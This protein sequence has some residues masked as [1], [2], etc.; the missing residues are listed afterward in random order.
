MRNEGTEVLYLSTMLAREVRN[1]IGM[2]EAMQSSSVDAAMQQARVWQK[3]KP[4][5]AASLK[6]HGLPVLLQLQSR[7]NRIDAIVKG[8]QAGDPWDELTSTILLLAGVTL[9][10]P[11][12]GKPE[13]NLL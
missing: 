9:S 13:A 1:L 8:V 5:V 12:V 4:L 7:V 10:L 2:S 6:R 11:D 3:R